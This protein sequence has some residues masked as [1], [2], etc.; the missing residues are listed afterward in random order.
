M[1]ILDLKSNKL[2]MNPLADEYDFFENL[3]LLKTEFRELT[4]MQK[5]NKEFGLDILWQQIK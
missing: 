4:L 3:E 1:E 2:E 5:V